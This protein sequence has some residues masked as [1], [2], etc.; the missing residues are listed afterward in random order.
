MSTVAPVTAGL[1]HPPCHLE[2]PY[3]RHISEA[4]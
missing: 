4:I 3:Y 1:S 2:R